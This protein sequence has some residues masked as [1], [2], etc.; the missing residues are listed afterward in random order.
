[1]GQPQEHGGGAIPG[2]AV[3]STLNAHTQRSG[4]IHEKMT[5]E[6][7]C[8]GCCNSQKVEEGGRWDKHSSSELHD[9]QMEGQ[10][11]RKEVYNVRNPP[12]EGIEKLEVRKTVAVCIIL[13]NLCN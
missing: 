2:E 8:L 13:E 10:D 9:Q 6:Q 4:R 5:P 12:G 7:Y 11:Q 1:M 3:T